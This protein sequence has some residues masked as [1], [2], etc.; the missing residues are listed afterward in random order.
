MSYKTGIVKAIAD[1][2]DRNNRVVVSRSEMK[3]PFGLRHEKND[4]A[5]NAVENLPRGVML[6]GAAKLRSNGLTGKGIKVAVIDSGVDELHSGF[7]GKVTKQ[8]WF[9]SGSLSGGD[10][11]GTHVAGTIHMMAPDAEIYDYRV[12]GEEGEFEVEDAIPLAIYEAVL[13]G[14]QVINM[15]LG[16]RFASSSTLSAVKY[17]HARGVIVVCAA[18]NEG[19]GNPLTNE[20]AFPAIWDQCLSIAAVSKE[21]DLPVANFSNSNPHVDYA[22]IGFEVTSF[23]SYGGYLTI[24]GTSMASPHVAGLIAALLSGDNSFGEKKGVRR[25][26]LKLLNE[27]FLIDIGQPG[28]DN[29]SGL[30]LLTYLTKD[31]FDDMFKER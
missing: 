7:D 18:G 27:M 26:M 23:Q 21:K 9:R 10:E 17:A 19:D 5:V 16:G 12:F 4:V 2:K 15:S 13:D 31:E 25:N 29:E 14:C 24:S 28:F 1:L 30:G 3:I 6:T 22:G 8:V 20:R 11:H